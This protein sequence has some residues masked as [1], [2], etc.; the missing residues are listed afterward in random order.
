MSDLQATLT[1]LTKGLIYS[2]EADFPVK[3]FLWKKADVGAEPLTPDKIKTLLQIKP[4]SP[5]ETI[6]S[7][8]FFEPVVTIEN[9][10]GDEEK[11]T[12]AQ[13]QKLAETLKTDLTDVA[14][15]KIGDSKKTVVVVG[16]TQ[17]GDYTGVTTKVVET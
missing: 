13:F 16:K 2:S 1:T 5:V 4:N 17:E 15:Y 14:V 9:W 8:A 12:A 3:P 11:Q 6:T 7:E 10:F